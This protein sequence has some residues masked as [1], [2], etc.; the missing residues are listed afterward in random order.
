MT[1]PLGNPASRPPATTS[2]VTF[3]VGSAALLTATCGLCPSRVGDGGTSGLP[4]HLGASQPLPGFPPRHQE[5]GTRS[6][7]HVT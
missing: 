3:Y 4:A 1:K 7:A 6:Q 5:P 2:V